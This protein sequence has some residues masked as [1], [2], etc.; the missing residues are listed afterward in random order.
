ML[1]GIQLDTSDTAIP[2]QSTGPA[3]H[4]AR[5]RDRLLAGPAALADYEILEMLLFL[6]IPRR[7]TKPQAKGLINRFGSLAAALTAGGRALRAAGLEQRAIEAFGLVA[8]AAAQLSRAESGERV[9]LG[10][11][12]ALERYLNLPVRMMQPPA[13]SALLLNNRNQLLAEHRWPHSVDAATLGREMLRHALERH[14][15]AVILLRNQGEALPELTREDRALHA[16]LQRAGAAILVLVHDLVVIGGG[17][18][19]SLRQQ[20]SLH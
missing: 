12:T 10:N 20:G 9:M 5:M 19:I 3:G 13:F 7:D 2:F 4:R 14:A 17:E 6:G 18:W 8:E 16:Q 15:T 1:G 11:W